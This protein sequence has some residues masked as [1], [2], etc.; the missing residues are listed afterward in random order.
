MARDKRY[1][2]CFYNALIH[3]ID[4]ML[5]TNGGVCPAKRAELMFT[6]HM[7]WILYWASSVDVNLFCLPIKYRSPLISVKLGG[8]LE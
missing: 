8:R 2:I 7:I 3:S 5:F 1:C 4:V 6:G